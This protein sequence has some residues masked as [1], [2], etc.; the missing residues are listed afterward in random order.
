MRQEN[1]FANPGTSR[2]FLSLLKGNKNPKAIADSLKIRSPPVIEQLKRLRKNKLVKLGEKEGK[3][4]NYEIIWEEFL[5]IF[6]EEAL[7]LRRKRKDGIIEEDNPESLKRIREMK[8]NKYFRVL[9]EAYLKNIADGQISEWNS[10]NA[11]MDNFENAIGQCEDV[12]NPR[13]AINKEEK[14]FFETI[15]LWYDKA[16]SAQ[17]WLDVCLH[18]AVI[19]TLRL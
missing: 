14:E 13:K 2:V 15:R 16:I 3:E 8:G 4:Q 17:T 11:A 5:P 10:V 18:D 7:Q 9:V 12:K 1:I 19:K 6:I